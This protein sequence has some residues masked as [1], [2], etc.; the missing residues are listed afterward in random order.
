MVSQGC[1]NGVTLLLHCCYIIVTLVL[2][3]CYTV[4][5]LLSHCYHTV[6]TRSARGRGSPRTGSEHGVSTV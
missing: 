2:H 3:C 5:T 1:Y 4:V 6:F